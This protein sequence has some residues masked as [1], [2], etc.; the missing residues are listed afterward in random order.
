MIVK[1]KFLS[2]SGPKTDIDRVIEQYLSKYEIQLENAIT[3]LKTTENLIPFMDVNPYKELLNKANEYVRILKKKAGTEKK[4]PAS[5]EEAREFLHN[6]NQEYQALAEEKQRVKEQKQI[7]KERLAL[8]SPFQNLDLDL[9][10]VANFQ[11]MRVRFGRIGLD[12]YG[13]LEKYLYDDLKAIFFESMRDENYVYGCYYVAAKESG[14]IDSIFKSFHFETIQIP[15]EYEGKPVYLCKDAKKKIKNCNEV[16]NRLKEEMKQCLLDRADT[17]LGV[18]YYLEEKYNN[19]DVRKQAAIIDNEQEDYYLLCGWMS[20]KDTERFIRDTQQDDNINIIVEDEK[21]ETFG[22]PPTKMKNPRFFRPFEMFIRMYGLPAHNEID[23]TMFVA[24]TYTFIFGAM[25]GDVGQ[26]LCLLLGGGFLYL[27]KRINLAGI[28]SV[29][30]IFS[31]FFGFMYGSFFGFEGTVIEPK[32]L[33]PMSAMMKLPMVGQL[34]TVFIVAVAFGMALI[35]LAMIFQVINAWKRGDLT[36]MLFSPNGIAGIVFYG[37]VV[38]T[39]VLYMSGKTLP[40]TAL[41]AV[42]LGVPI[43]LFLFREPLGEL[44]EGKKVEI[45]GG[46]GMFVMQGIFELIETMLSYFSNTLSFVR[47]GAF[48]V[49]HAAMMEVVLM[50]GGITEGAGTPNWLVIVLGNIFV[51]G[52]E[53]LIVGIQVLRLEYYEMFSRFYSG[54]GREFVPFRNHKKRA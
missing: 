37:C 33:S 19:F 18:R 14:K 26:G 54:S 15:K 17:I 36:N 7:L 39:V 16:L 12:Y 48:A 1:M 41:L 38:L 43:L 32:W 45:E 5:D 40:G 50:L 27:W 29:A 30:G 21:E 31:T 49:S 53:G 35:L 23:P 28:I 52:M 42:F 20:E 25:F 34:N 22:T 24:L 3:E 2:I 4:L 6:I 13:K 47:V 10:E 46:K 44:V 9:S 51:C 8:L 11:Y